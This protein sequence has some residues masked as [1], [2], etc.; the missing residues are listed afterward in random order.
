MSTKLF[1]VSPEEPLG[2]V[3]AKMAEK[4]IGIALIVN[5]DG[6]LVGVFSERNLLW[7]FG[8]QDAG[9]ITAPIGDVMVTD[10][11]TV[12]ESDDLIECLNTLFDKPYRHL[13]VAKDKKPVGVLSFRSKN[14]LDILI[15]FEKDKAR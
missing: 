3:V 1:T 13:I 5:D 11:E 4:E 15:T 12:N 8:L 10:V 6:E 7:L 14:L 9:L 2:S